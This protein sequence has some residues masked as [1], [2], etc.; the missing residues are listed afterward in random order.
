MLLNMKNGGSKALKGVKLE[1]N[2]KYN[3]LRFK[4]KIV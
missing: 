1:M 2:K 3:Q 4:D